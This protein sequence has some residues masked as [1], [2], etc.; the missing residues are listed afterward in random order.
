MSTL[1]LLPLVEITDGVQSD[2]DWRLS[3]AYYLDDGV[4]PIP[5]TGLSFTLSVG[6]FAILSSS[7]GQ[8]VASGPSNNVL[9]ITELAA[10]KSA[11]PIGVYPI[12]L[13]V[14]DGTY[15]RDLFASS[16]LTIGA[17]QITHVTLVAAPDCLATSI[18]AQVPTALAAALQALQPAALAAALAAL[19]GADLAVLTQAI[20]A[21]LPVQSGAGA[22]AASG[23]PFINSSGFVVIAQ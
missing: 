12:A 7:A 22:P 6:A 18:A 3:I 11:W 14:N 1:S 23:Q 4:T 10:A 20:F 19:S 13:S 16:T 2:E 21:A 8:I 5:L 9:V 15:T 17:A